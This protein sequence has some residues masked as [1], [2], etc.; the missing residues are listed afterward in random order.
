MVLLFNLDALDLLKKC[1][2]FNPNDRISVEKA[3]KH[4]Y[5]AEF[6][7]PEEVCV[8]YKEIELGRTIIIPMDDNIKFSIQ[9]YREALYN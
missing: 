2:Q 6:S 9:E 5:L 1:L 8:Q 7:E 3:L 4:P